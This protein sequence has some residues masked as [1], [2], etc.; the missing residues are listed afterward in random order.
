M[1]MQGDLDLMVAVGEGQQQRLT[2]QIVHSSVAVAV[3]Q[4]IFAPRL[5]SH[6]ELQSPVQQV[7]HRMALEI[8]V[9]QI[10]HL[11]VKV[12]A[13]RAEL[14]LRAMALRVALAH[15][16]LAEVEMV[17]QAVRSELV[18]LGEIAE[19]ARQLFTAVVVVA[20]ATSAVV[21]EIPVVMAN[22]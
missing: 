22:G 1:L 12:V 3:A 15:R 9:A 14:S 17:E 5:R 20:L 19:V 10:L 18:E 2:L 11:V 7:V 8:H 21:V 4:L 13:L 16:A 6:H